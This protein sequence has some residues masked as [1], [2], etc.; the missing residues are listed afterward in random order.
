MRASKTDPTPVRL[1]TLL[2]RP[3]LRRPT[4]IRTVGL[5]F[6]VKLAPV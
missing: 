3:T 2:S 4:P 1:R 5:R 6:N